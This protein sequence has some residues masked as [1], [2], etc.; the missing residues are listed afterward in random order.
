MTA[1]YEAI[2]E[3]P[4]MPLTLDGRPMSPQPPDQTTTENGDLQQHQ[5]LLKVPSTSPLRPRR[6]QSSTAVF[7]H[8]LRLPPTVPED[9]CL[10]ALEHVTLSSSPRRPRASTTMSEARESVDRTVEDSSWWSEE[11][12]KRREIRR[13]WKEAEDENIVVIGN[14]VDTNHPNYVTAYNMLTGLRVAVRG[15][16]TLHAYPRCLESVQKLIE[17]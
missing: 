3:N 14:R 7:H 12:H 6:T 8:P 13:R 10:P 5:S 11:I 15:R 17:N 16:N 4:E 9:V 1:S 2:Q